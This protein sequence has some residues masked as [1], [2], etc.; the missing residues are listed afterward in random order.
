MKNLSWAA[1]GIAGFPSIVPAAA[2]GKNKAPAPS[3]RIVM[4]GIGFGN[5]GLGNLDSFLNNDGVQWVAVC[6]VDDKI[7]AR[8]RDIVNNAG[9][10][11]FLMI[12]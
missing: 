6:D 1:A 2:L 8:A 3:D 7:R 9:D 11:I 5:M 12:V 4:A 10:T